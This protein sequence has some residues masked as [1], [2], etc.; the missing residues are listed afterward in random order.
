[1]DPLE[2]PAG[3]G[4]ATCCP[5]FFIPFFGYLF[6]S[7]FP[8]KSLPNRPPNPQQIAPKVDL[9]SD[10]SFGHVFIDFSTNKIVN[11]ST[12]NPSQSDLANKSVTSISI[13]KTHMNLTVST[14]YIT[15]ISKKS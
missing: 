2:V 6:A 11:K 13:E 5:L 9:I 12:D 7:L 14:F 1:M 8:P 4:M 15:E 10:A 3:M